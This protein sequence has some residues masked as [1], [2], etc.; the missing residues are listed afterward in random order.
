MYLIKQIQEWREKQGLP[1][2][3]SLKEMIED[4]RDD[5]DCHSDPDDSCELCDLINKES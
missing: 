4:M 2:Y 5:H 1:R 3:N